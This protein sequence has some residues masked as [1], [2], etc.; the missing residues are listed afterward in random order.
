M[1]MG[2]KEKDVH[3]SSLIESVEIEMTTT[4]HEAKWSVRRVVYRH[5]QYINQRSQITILVFKKI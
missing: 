5:I 1:G 4:R 2:K 3:L